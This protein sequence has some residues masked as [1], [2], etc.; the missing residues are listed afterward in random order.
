M[1]RQQAACSG[2][3]QRAAVKAAGTHEALSTALSRAVGECGGRW[4]THGGG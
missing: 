1:V 2:R 4:P 3:A